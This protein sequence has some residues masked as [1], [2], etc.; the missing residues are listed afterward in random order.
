MTTHTAI[1][2]VLAICCALSM[3]CSLSANAPSA[4][5]PTLPSVTSSAA[6]T[7]NTPS[8]ALPTLSAERYTVPGWVNVRACASLSCAVVGAIEAGEAVDADCDRSGWCQVSGGWV[9]Y[10]C[11]IGVCKSK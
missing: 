10:S 7:A 5:L 9:K 6:P 3:A 2:L 1:S 4:A 11:L 8:T